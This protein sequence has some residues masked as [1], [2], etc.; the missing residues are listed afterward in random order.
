L[1]P[2]SS[3][4]PL[5]FDDRGI[6]SACRVEEEK[7][8][9]DWD[10]R[11]KEL[12]KI[13]EQYRSKDGNYDCIIPVSGG[14]D[15]HYQTY[16]IKEVFKMNPL[17]VTFN[18]QWNTAAGIRNLEN[19]VQK[20]GCDHIRFSPDPKLIPRLARKSLKT[21]GDPC[22]H[23]HA[24][25]TTFPVQI[26]VKYKIPLLIWGEQGF[27]DLG[28]MFSLEDKVEMTRKVR[29]EQELRGYDAE[30]LVDE[31]EGIT[32]D[33]LRWAKYPSDAELES[34]GV[35]GVFMGNYIK[36]DSKPQTD[37]MIKDYGFETAEFQRTYNTQWDVECWHDNGLH[38]WLKY[39]KFGYGRATDHAN[40][41]IRFGR[42][43]REE[44]IEM[45]R[46]YDALRPDDLDMFLKFVDMTEEEFVAC[47]DTM[48]SP[49]AWKKNEQ[50][51]WEMPDNV[52]D[53]A[54]DPGVE[55]ARLPIV[56][57][58]NY[59]LTDSPREKDEKRYYF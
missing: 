54:N 18:H 57:D 58:H 12:G 34:V 24:G 26:A 50:G 53:H 16:L 1:L 29:K 33:D 9:I 13:L 45:V 27:L 40:K 49:I 38:D 17:L 11:F 39:L 22:W 44:G 35:R 3:A 15:S 6:C 36:W 10:V 43:T 41:D 32:A 28:G 7:K 30:D 25:L 52:W 56:G 31:E 37:K 51:A 48:R 47:V 55:E 46:K 8:K 5:T 21:M 14:K 23:C 42:M 19:M 2:E 20:F 59:S 4:V